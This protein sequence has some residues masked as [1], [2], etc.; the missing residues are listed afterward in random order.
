LH[1]LSYTSHYR[2]VTSSLSGT[3]LGHAAILLASLADLLLGDVPLV[4]G[5]WNLAGEVGLD[6]LLNVA[7]SARR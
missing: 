3:L 2:D 6:K 7:E 4:A 1:S 5:D